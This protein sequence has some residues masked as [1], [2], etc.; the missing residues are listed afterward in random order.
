MTSKS[1]KNTSV[2]G[3]GAVD[4]PATGKEDKDTGVPSVP[5]GKGKG[6]GTGT[7]AKDMGMDTGVPSVPGVPD[8]G[9]HYHN[10][11][12]R[13]RARFLTDNGAA[14]PDYELLELLLFG[15]IPRADVKNTAKELL[16]RFGSIERVL[17]SDRALLQ[18]VPGISESGAVALK[19]MH[20]LLA[21]ARKHRFE[22]QH[23]L[24]NWEE[25]LEYLY[26]TM[27]ERRDE[28][29]RLILLNSLSVVMEE[30]TIAQ[31][32]NAQ[33]MIDA[34][35]IVEHVILKRAHG[36]IMVHNHPSGDKRPSE[37]DVELTIKV[38]EL[39]E[40][41]GLRM[42]DHLIVARNGITSLRELL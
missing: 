9:V 5:K 27:S 2:P 24:R 30:I 28:E 19:C 42:I 31:G 13:L 29:L 21:R 23:V 41:M 25:I 11:R 34:P 20:L 15:V 17:A 39:C 37:E 38:D 26:T 14:M 6:K 35:M 36:F 4:D 33:I 12:K 8:T 10:H 40:Q 16:R 1:P 7:G 32:N 3:T 22:K 18:E